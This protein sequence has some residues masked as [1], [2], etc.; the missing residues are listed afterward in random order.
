[1][2]LELVPDLRGMSVSASSVVALVVLVLVPGAR[3]LY[4]EGELTTGD[5]W[6]FMA[7]LGAKT[8]TLCLTILKSITGSTSGEA[9]L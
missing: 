3:G 7:R 2:L 4:L 5:N 8:N 9:I 6:V 1:M